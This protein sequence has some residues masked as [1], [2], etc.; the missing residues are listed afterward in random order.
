M[1]IVHARKGLVW[2]GLVVFAAQAWAADPVPLQ[3]AEDKL[4]YGIGASIGKNLRSETSGVNLP[5]LIEGLQAGLG[6]EKLRLT[7][8]E[9]RQV[10]AD[11]QNQLRKRVTVERQKAL[12]E[13]KQRGDEY[14]AANKAKADVKVLPSGVQYRVLKAG[15][16]NRPNESDT[17]VVNYRGTLINGTEFDS[18][19]PDHP[20][21]LKIAALIPGWRNAL[22]AMPVG[23]KWAMA[24]PSTL[25][26]GERGVGTD[27]GPN[28]VL[29]F[30]VELLAIK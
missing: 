28:E 23:S 16:G 29:L 19:Q 14:L 18:T 13:N 20:A 22:L 7:E 15:E 25:A 12:N 4:S 11:Y 5:L 10:M 9:L 3:S 1:K 30:D 6:A 27:I 26:Y 2:V 17:V 21:N 24:I 8:P